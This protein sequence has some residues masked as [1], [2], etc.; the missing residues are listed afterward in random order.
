MDQRTPT[1]LEAVTDT[2]ASARSD[3]GLSR[4]IGEC[5]S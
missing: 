2:K 1:N 4:A 3:S 5:E